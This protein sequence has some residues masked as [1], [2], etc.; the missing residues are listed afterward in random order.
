M[1]EYDELKLYISNYFDLFKNA[2]INELINYYGE[3]YRDQIVSRVNSPSYI[4]YVNSHISFGRN[5]LLKAYYKSVKSVIESGKRDR[6]MYNSS[7]IYLPGHKKLMDGSETCFAYSYNDFKNRV[8]SAIYIQLF[9]NNDEGIIHEMIHASV[10]SPLCLA[11]NGKKEE[12]KYK[13][14]LWVLDHI[15]EMK[16]EEWITQIEARII[17]KRLKEK[18]VSFINKYYPYENYICNYNN[19]IPY[20]RD[21]YETYRNEIT[22][23]RFT[24]NLG[25][26]L[27][28]IGKENY[29]EYIELTKGLFD[30]YYDCDRSFYKYFL[31]KTL[32]KMNEESTLTLSKN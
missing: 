14:G 3:K 30:N 5:K 18:G 20:V 8:D 23:A 22:E 21:F 7:K 15:G 16:L 31:E 28:I 25:R 6:E 10:G 13:N 27:H 1:N 32:E 17:E 19:F 12:L 26:F 4:F 11:S 9:D 2:A 29:C 24:L